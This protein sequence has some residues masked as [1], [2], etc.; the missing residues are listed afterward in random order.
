MS[1]HSLQSLDFFFSFFSVAALAVHLCPLPWDEPLVSFSGT[2]PSVGGGA[3]AAGAAAVAGSVS[4]S[5]SPSAAMAASATA[6]AAAAAVVAESVGTCGLPGKIGQIGKTG[7]IGTA[8]KVG[9]VGKNGTTGNVGTMGTTERL[10]IGPGDDIAGDEGDGAGAGAGGSV[11]GAGAGGGC[12]GGAVVGLHGLDLDDKRYPG[13]TDAKARSGRVG[14]RSRGRNRSLGGG[15]SDGG[16]TGGK[17]GSFA[18]TALERNGNAHRRGGSGEGGGAGGSESCNVDGVERVDGGGWGAEG[19]GDGHGGGGNGGGDRGDSGAA[20]SRLASLY[21]CLIPP[22]LVGVTNQP[23]AGANLALVFA[24]C[25]GLLAFSWGRLVARD[26][27]ERAAEAAAAAMDEEWNN[28]SEHGGGGGAAGEGNLVAPRRTFVSNGRGGSGGVG[29]GGVGGGDVV[30]VVEGRLGR[31]FSGGGGN[32]ARH[33]GV[34]RSGSGSSSWAL[35][36]EGGTDNNDTGGADGQEEDM[37]ETPRC[38]SDSLSRVHLRRG[39][40]RNAGTNEDSGSVDGGDG[41]SNLIGGVGGGLPHEFL[42]PA[43]TARA[44]GASTSGRRGPGGGGAIVRQESSR[45]RAWCCGS[46][47]AAAVAAAAAAAAAAAS[48]SSSNISV[49]GTGNRAAGGGSGVLGRPTKCGKLCAV[50]RS[51]KRVAVDRRL[52]DWRELGIGCT[53]FALGLGCFAAQGTSATAGWYHLWHG[54]WHVLALGSTVHILR[55]R[56]WGPQEFLPEGK[57]GGSSSGGGGGDVGDG[58]GGGGGGGAESGVWAQ[59]SGLGQPG[60]SGSRVARW[61]SGW[62]WVRRRFGGRV[63]TRSYEMVP[64]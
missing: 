12:G 59:G 44:R 24:M 57:D 50:L 28:E 29:G 42:L 19:G 55:A 32:G 8:G 54:A 34:D 64:T 53:G 47:T 36:K 26:L 18:T 10:G 1:F 62:A 2:P 25:G 52:L 60:V 37:L 61:R 41:V 48:S 17:K 11:A 16:G 56:K 9:T 30:G 49:G 51:V 21:V 38:R 23:T 4:M 40:E 46:T 22:L 63:E 45:R 27:Y 20:G 7:K 3:A 58:G 43:R 13:M 35:R 39:R 15:G 33:G 14:G 5:A 6:S 31:T